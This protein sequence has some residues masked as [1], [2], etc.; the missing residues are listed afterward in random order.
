MRKSLVLEVMLYLGMVFSF[1]GIQEAAPTTTENVYIPI[2]AKGL[3]YSFWESVRLGAEEAARDLGI[4]ITFEGPQEEAQTQ[5]QLDMLN[6][7][8]SRSPQAVILSAVDSRAVT[9]YLEEAQAKGIPVIGFDSGVDSPIVRTTVATDNYGAGEL[10]AEKMVELLDK[11][12][13][14]AIIIQD[15]TSQVATNRRDGFIDTITQQY[16]SMDVV[17]VGYGEGD[18]K[19]SSEIA[20]DIFKNH[21]DLKGIFGGN[22][23]SAEGIAKALRELNKEGEIT[24]IGFDS[25]NILTEAIRDGIIVGAVS[26]NP[27]EIGYKAVETAFKAYRGETL[28]AFIDTGYVWYDKSNI[29]NPEIKEFLYK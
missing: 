9:P 12:G 1:S 29:D 3:K 5:Q 11:K 28:P 15:A 7:A 24:A 16:P 22:Q 13:K 8:L 25:G 18:A 10:A 26:Q 27:K 2:I 6:I 20:K 23:G 4:K 19:K 21:P 17:A 14:V